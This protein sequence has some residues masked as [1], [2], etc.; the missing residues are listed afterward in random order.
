VRL[1]IFLIALAVVLADQGTK[2]WMSRAL[3]DRY[4]IPVMPWLAWE[5][6]HNSGAAFGVLGG[7]NAL[8]IGAAA[9]AISLLLYWVR[10]VNSWAMAAALG[11]LLGGALGNLIDRIRLGHVVDFIAIQYGGRTVFPNFNVAD[12]AISVGAVLLAWSWYRMEH[13][14]QAEAGEGELSPA[15]SPPVGDEA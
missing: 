1:K 2:S 7:G 9:V 10:Y 12:T 11:F 8:L 15:S 13:A 14:R 3:E 4:L 6:S 5:L